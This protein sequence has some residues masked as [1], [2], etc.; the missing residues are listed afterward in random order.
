MSVS[1]KYVQT[2]TSVQRLRSRMSQ[3]L[4]D[5]S[6]QLS[7]WTV[8]ALICN[9]SPHPHTNKHRRCKGVMEVR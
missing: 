3:W 8:R 5:A 7:S 4:K 2:P 6:E 1:V 9:P